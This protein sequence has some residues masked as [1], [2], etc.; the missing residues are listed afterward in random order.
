[1]EVNGRGNLPAEPRRGLHRRFFAFYGLNYGDGRSKGY[2][3]YR[4]NTAGVAV[5]GITGVRA[6][7]ISGNQA[8]IYGSATITGGGYSGTH[9]YVLTVQDLSG[10]G[11]ADHFK[12]EMSNGYTVESSIV[13]GDIKIRALPVLS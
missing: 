11:T 5:D 13:S 9:D 6:V 1:V 2:L 3:S 8:V 10:G 4:D 7:V 12:L